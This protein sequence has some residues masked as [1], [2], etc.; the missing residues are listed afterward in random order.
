M[1]LL[2]IQN[3]ALVGTDLNILTGQ[4]ADGTAVTLRR[5]MSGWEVRLVVEVA[6]IVMH[7]AVPTTH[8]ITQFEQLRGQAHD[9]ADADRSVFRALALESAKKE[10]L[11]PGAPWCRGE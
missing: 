1:N 7:D 3:P 2:A 9:R 5:R 8:E 11:F 10:G 6:G 4:L